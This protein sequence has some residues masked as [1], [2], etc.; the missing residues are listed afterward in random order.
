MGGKGAPKDT[1][2]GVIG[3]TGMD[4]MARSLG[5]L[6]ISTTKGESPKKSAEKATKLVKNTEHHLLGSKSHTAIPGVH[7]GQV[8]FAGQ[9]M[10]AVGAQ[11]S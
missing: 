3:R 11:V 10:K 4:P 2:F 1:L 5:G 7:T 9:Y 8:P 6:V